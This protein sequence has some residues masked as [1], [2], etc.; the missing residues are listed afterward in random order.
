MK[1]RRSCAISFKKDGSIKISAALSVAGIFDIFKTILGENHP[2]V[3]CNET[4]LVAI[5][6]GCVSI[7][8]TDL[9]D[10]KQDIASQRLRVQEDGYTWLHCQ[11]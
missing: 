4:A 8:M 3:P 11:N 6:C 5:L 1:R 2:S 7:N 9:V 10:F